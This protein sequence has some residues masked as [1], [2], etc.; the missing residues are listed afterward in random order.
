MHLAWPCLRNPLRAKRHIAAINT[1]LS[2]KLH[3][4]SHPLQVL[5]PYFQKNITQ[6]YVSEEEAGKRLAKVVA[7]PNYNQSGAY[8]SW[9]NDSEV[10]VNTPSDEVLDDSKAAKCFDCSAKLVGLKTA[11]P[12]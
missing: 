3:S 4:H 9:S 7:D 10:F 5:F 12:A 2:A 6:G 11:V 8:W 1:A